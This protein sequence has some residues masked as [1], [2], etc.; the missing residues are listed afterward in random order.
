MPNGQAQTSRV[1]LADERITVI[2]ARSGLELAIRRSSTRSLGKVISRPD[3]ADLIAGVAIEQ[4]QL[5]PD[6]RGFFTELSRLG[7][8]GIASRMIPDG[9][10][11]IQIA[12]TLTYPGTIKAI[13]ITSRRTC[14]H[15]SLECCRCFCAIYAAAQQHLALSTRSMSE[16]SDR[17]KS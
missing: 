4:L 1:S 9:E 12:V 3:S 14:G 8:A 2:G 7:S 6:D 10:R 15:R 5:H 11:R 13:H 16:C 17:G